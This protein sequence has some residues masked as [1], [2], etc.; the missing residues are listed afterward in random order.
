MEY[1]FRCADLGDSRIDDFHVIK[2]CKK[3][4]YLLQY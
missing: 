2:H 1:Q 4:P 3:N